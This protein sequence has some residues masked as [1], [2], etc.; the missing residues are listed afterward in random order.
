MEFFYKVIYG[1]L[2]IFLLGFI[3]EY[4]MIFFYNKNIHQYFYPSYYSYTFPE[5]FFPCKKKYLLNYQK[6]VSD[7]Y[8]LMKTKKVVIAGLVRDSIGVLPSTIAKIEA[9]G[10][11]FKEYQVVVFEND[12]KDGSRELLKA[13]SRK[14]QAV[15]LLE[16]QGVTDCRLNQLKMYNYGPRSLNRMEKMALFRNQYLRFIQEK[17]TDFDYV[18]I[19]DFDLQGPWSNDGIAHSIAQKDWDGVFAYGLHSLLGSFGLVYMMYDGL[20]YVHKYDKYDSPKNLFKNYFYMNFIDLYASVKGSPLVPV[21]SSFSGLALYKLESFLCGEY[22]AKWPCEHIGLHEKMAQK[23]H[24]KFF[25]NPSLLLLSGHQG[26]Q[27]L[28]KMLW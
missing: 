9:T 5:N 26:P 6:A 25:I 16:C 12:S 10:N 11:C 19:I 18:L 24:D 15:H 4:S 3:F 8:K 28:L 21:K 2:L 7:G 14:N 1:L 20:A 23:G 27:N 22:N 13:W 17:Y